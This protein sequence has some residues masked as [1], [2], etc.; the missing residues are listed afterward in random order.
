MRADVQND[1]VFFEYD[2]GTVQTLPSSAMHPPLQP[3]PQN[4]PSTFNTDGGGGNLATGNRP[5]PANALAIQSAMEAHDAARRYQQHA[6]RMVIVLSWLL[7]GLVLMVV[8]F[9]AFLSSSAKDNPANSSTVASNQPQ[10]AL[11]Y[12]PPTSTQKS[13]A[14]PTQ[15]SS[16]ASYNNNG[17]DD[18]LVPLDTS[19]VPLEKNVSVIND[20][21][22]GASQNAS[23]PDKIPS[24]DAPNQSHHNTLTSKNNNYNTDGDGVDMPRGYRM[25]NKADGKWYYYQRD[26]DALPTQ[27]AF[28]GNPIQ[29]KQPSH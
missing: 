9:L 5:V 8:L 12:M 14:I 3:V 10:P 21:L 7:V 23:N 16:D 17:L 27:D 2:D 11:M 6:I 1:R 20:G 28:S 26:P 15:T 25:R 19:Q 29:A 18:L 13:T 22:E 24:Y 4:P